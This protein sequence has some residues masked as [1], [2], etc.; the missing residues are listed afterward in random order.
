M[1]LLWLLFLVVSLI[2]NSKSDT[3]CLNNPIII[4]HCQSGT[5]SV[6]CIQSH[7]SNDTSIDWL[8][9]SSPEYESYI[10]DFINITRLTPDTFTNF[11][12]RFSSLNSLQFRFTNGVDEIA[13]NTFQMLSNYSETHIS[14][15]FN[16]PGNFQLADHAFG[17]SKYHQILIADGQQQQTYQLNLKAFDRA[18]ISGLSIVNCNNIQLIRNEPLSLT[19]Q[20]VEIKKSLLANA[21]LLI[22]SLS[23]S[24]TKLDLSSNQLVHVPS[25]AK[26]TGLTDIDLHKNLIE[27]I[28]ANTFINLTR[29]LRL[30]LS[31]NRMKRISHEAFAELHLTILTLNDNHLTSLETV[32]I[33]NEKTSFLNPLNQSLTTLVLSNNLL[34]DFDPIRN[35][36]HLNTLQLCCNQIK[37]LYEDSFQNARQLEIIDLS[38][39]HIGSIHP[40]TFKATKVK[41]LDLSSNPFSS[42]ETTKI[43]YDEDFKRKNQTNS[44]LEHITSTLTNLLL[45]NCTN[46]L[47][48]NWFLFK[49]T[50]I[51]YNLDLSGTPKTDKFWLYQPRNY[52]DSAVQGQMRQFIVTVMSI[53][54]TNNDYCLFKPVFQ[55]LNHTILLLDSNHPCNCFVF[56]MRNILQMRVPP[57]CLSNQSIIDELSQQCMNIDVSC[58]FPTSSTTMSSTPLL[59]STSFTTI[60]STI[61]ITTVITTIPTTTTIPATI[62][63]T[64]ATTT[65][66][67]MTTT[68]TKVTTTTKTEESTT[69]VTM[70]TIVTTLGATAAKDDGKWK[71]ILAIMLPL[72]VIIVVLSSVS[73]YI[74]QKRKKNRSKEVIELRGGLANIFAN[75]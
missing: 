67:S 71:T 75:K 26:F 48:I 65:T 46:L 17:Q 68:T 57:I 35:L 47:E 60:D 18:N 13:E 66:A 69:S 36:T 61:P 33:H 19:I 20:E 11:R 30:N 74:V 6:T 32:T 10:F 4:C 16:S 70:T 72:T 1:F 55:I 44:F 12:S 56:M 37:G 22:Q 49:N 42:L 34:H 23:N 51:L 2:S 8:T 50:N 41:H 45:K 3:L 7:A 38:S 31:Y 5:G 27:E 53:N 15:T 73:I 52:N 28:H 62:T 59:S 64:T 58:A 24:L 40:L 21:D 43:V 29:L 63:T 14:L 54:F 39:N 25:L 9:F